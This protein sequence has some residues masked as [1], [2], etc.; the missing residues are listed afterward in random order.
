MTTD[1][2]MVV[3]RRPG[4]TNETLPRLL[5]VA[6]AEDGRV[7]VWQNGSN[8]EVTDIVKSCSEHSAMAGVRHDPRNSP[9]REATN[10]LWSETEGDFIAKVDDDCLVPTGWL[11]GLVAQHG[12]GEHFGALCAWHFPASDFDEVLARPKIQ[13][14]G[15]VTLMRN[16]WVAGSGYVM[17]RECV[18]DCQMIELDESWYD[19]CLRASMRGWIF[20]WP[21]PLILQNHLDDPRVEGSGIQDDSDLRSYIP[22]SAKSLGV[23]TVEDWIEALRADARFIQTASIHRYSYGRMAKVARS[24]G[25]RVKLSNVASRRK[26]IY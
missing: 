13:Q 3:H 10:W 14:V 19:Y 21:L 25:R 11:S 12:L 15:G 8:A 18:I 2:L 16:F 24:V 9:L 6:A 4:Y 5:D 17:S 1:I 23:S 26:P 7:W 22:L 20:G